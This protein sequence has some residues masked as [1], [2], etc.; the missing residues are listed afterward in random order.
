MRRRKFRVS[1]KS[2]Y[3]WSNMQGQCADVTLSTL[4]SGHIIP[5][6]DWLRSAH[7]QV[8]VRP[9]SNEFVSK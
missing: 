5:V 1:L 3:I 2:L 4:C 8:G 7:S 9:T 6:T